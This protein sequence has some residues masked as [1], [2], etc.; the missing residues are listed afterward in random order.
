ME[1]LKVMSTIYSNGKTITHNFEVPANMHLDLL[2]DMSGQRL[3]ANY[4]FYA[5]Y[6]EEKLPQLMEGGTYPILLLKEMYIGDIVKQNLVSIDIISNN[7]PNL[8]SKTVHT[9]QI[10]FDNW[11]FINGTSGV[12]SAIK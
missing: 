11:Y 4:L 7:L 1:N 10:K 2:V 3:G 5:Y 9:L 8:A 12:V 6:K